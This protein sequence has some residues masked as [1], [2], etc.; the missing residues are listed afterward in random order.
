MIQN[1]FAANEDWLAERG[2]AYGKVLAPDANH[3]T[4][5]FACAE[6]IHDFARV[7]GLNTPAEVAE[8]RSRLS[9]RIE[10]HKAS[11]PE[12]VTTMVMSSENL[13]GN[14]RTQAEIRS[15]KS[16]L[17]QHFDDIEIVLYVRRQDDA[18]ISMYGEFMR[19]GFSD[20][21]FDQFIKTCAGPD[22]PVPYL[23]YRRELSKWISVWGKEKMVV[24]RFSPVDFIQGDILADFMG[25]V[26]RTWTPDM[27]GFKPSPEPNL[28]LSAPA[29]EFLRRLHPAIP[30]VKNGKPNEQRSKL[31]PFI[32]ALPKQP[33]P[34]MAAA[35]ARRIMDPFQNANRWLKNEFNPTLEGAFFPARADHPEFGNLGQLTLEDSIELTGQLLANVE[36]VPK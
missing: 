6:K 1:S 30:F 4:L 25:V 7:Y 11:L 14:L 2:I 31:T 28:G 10:E 12:H 16:F 26:Q 33:R 18:L 17:S 3:I 35:T 22:S 20:E 5:F 23:Y 24:R 9:R 19:R 13:L 36:I 27:E 29:L 32:N 15:L 34:V 21:T 8:F